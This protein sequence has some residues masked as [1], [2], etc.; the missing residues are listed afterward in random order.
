[1]VWCDLG[2]NP[3]LPD[4]RRTLNSLGQWV[5]LAINKA[6]LIL[7]LPTLCNIASILKE[8]LISL[9]LFTQCC[10]S[11]G[12]LDIPLPFQQTMFTKLNATLHNNTL[13][14]RFNKH[15]HIVIITTKLCLTAFNHLWNFYTII[16]NW[17]MNWLSTGIK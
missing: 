6:S 1:M 8:K 16:H 3:G 15:L 9:F 5:S 14:L 12:N 10:L 17:T 7:R 2:L 11:L 4:H 13:L